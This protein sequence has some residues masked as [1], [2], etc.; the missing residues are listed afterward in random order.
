M[1]TSCRIPYVPVL[2]SHLLESLAFVP[3]MI[4]VLMF[5]F[6]FFEDQ[7]P[8][9]PPLPFPQSF[10]ELLLMQLGCMIDRVFP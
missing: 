1:L 9:L 2:V 7:V 10:R 4:G 6:E 5:L 8:F 3:I